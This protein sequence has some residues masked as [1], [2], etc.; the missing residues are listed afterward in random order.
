MIVQRTLKVPMA[1]IEALPPDKGIDIVLAI[2]SAN[3]GYLKNFS[4]LKVPA[5]GSPSAG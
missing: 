1:E 3:K 4:G 2:V 5:P